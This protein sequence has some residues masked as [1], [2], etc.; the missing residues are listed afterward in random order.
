MK[1]G[2][3]VKHKTFNDKSY[4]VGYV[5]SIGFE[6]HDYCDKWESEC[7]IRWRDGQILLHDMDFIE[8]LQSASP[9]ELL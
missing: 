1:V 5:L 9:S 3:L 7:L 8:V 6:S 4:S 2:D